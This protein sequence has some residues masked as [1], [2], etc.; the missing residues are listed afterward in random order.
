M[1]KTSRIRSLALGAC[2]AVL[3]ATATA[4]PAAAASGAPTVAA[5]F[6][7]QRTSPAPESRASS[8]DLPAGQTRGAVVDVADGGVEIFEVVDATG[9]RV[10]YTLSAEDLSAAHAAATQVDIATSEALTVRTQ[11]AAASEVNVPLCVAAVAWFVAQTVFPAARVAALA[12]R[13]A[14]LVSKYGVQTVARIF[15]GA[16]GIAGRTAEQEIKEFALAATGVGGLAA[17]GIKF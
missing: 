3:A 11:S 2:L 7:D 6:Q 5:A 16:R 4:G 13:L 17:C 8:V 10:G 15:T 12:A 1:T 14:G 9:T